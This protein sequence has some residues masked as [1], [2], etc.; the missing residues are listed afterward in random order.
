MKKNLTL[1][2]L[3]SILWTTTASAEINFPYSQFKEIEFSNPYFSKHFENFISNMQKNDIKA[4]KE[5]D[6]AYEKYQKKYQKEKNRGV[7]RKPKEQQLIM[8][9]IIAK[10]EKPFMKAS[11]TFI[12]NEVSN[13][14]TFLKNVKDDKNIKQDEKINFIKSIKPLHNKY[15]KLFKTYNYKQ[16]SMNMN[17]FVEEKEYKYTPEFCGY[18]YSDLDENIKNLKSMTSYDLNSFVAKYKAA[19]T[20]LSYQENLKL[21]IEE[22]K[23]Y[24]SFKW[25]QNK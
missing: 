3:S 13:F 2:M 6:I 24:K 19:K 20:G 15:Q 1:I 4:S 17:C 25:E 7:Y 8:A 12:K 14:N 18:M 9:K 10:E 21:R 16:D 11:K 22:I 5:I 23:R